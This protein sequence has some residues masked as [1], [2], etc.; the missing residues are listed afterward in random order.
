MR[1]MTGFGRGATAAGTTRVVAEVRSVNHKYA[2][3]RVSLPQELAGLAGEVEGK[4]RAR[5]ARGRVEVAVRLEGP[6]GGGLRLDRDLARSVLIALEELRAE[7]GLSE[8]PS[9]SALAALPLVFQPTSSP[10]GA[11]G[12]RAAV[13]RAVD[14]A[15]EAAEAMRHAEGQALARD[16]DERLALLAS[17]IGPLRT[18]AAEVAPMVL[19]RLRARVERLLEGSPQSVDEGRLAQEVAM[20][21]DRTDVA[22]EL[23]R[24]ESHIAQFRTIAAEKGPVGRRLEFLLQEMGREASTIGAKVQDA[25]LQHMVVD[26]RGEIARMRE[27]VHNV[28]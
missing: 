5:F 22:E 16:F 12:L 1:S 8:P 14:E 23:T 28:E 21:A 7:L 4:L 15:L 9:V 18:L 17:Q 24:L 27:Q 3:V 10:D 6:S 2:D 11:E 25:R 13:R 26:L 19:E 20:L